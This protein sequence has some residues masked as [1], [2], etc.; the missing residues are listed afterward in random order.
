MNNRAR[1]QD[2]AEYDLRRRDADAEAVRDMRAPYAR[3][4]VS[5][6]EVKPAISIVGFQLPGARDVLPSECFVG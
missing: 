2:S 4:P 5:L 3:P 1:S 6:L